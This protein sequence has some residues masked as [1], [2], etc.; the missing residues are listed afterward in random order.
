MAVIFAKDRKI[1][2]FYSDVPPDLLQ[3]YGRKQLTEPLGEIPLKDKDA[4]NYLMKKK[5]AEKYDK[6][7][8]ELKGETTIS[9][10]DAD[11]YAKKAAEEYRSAKWGDFE[12]VGDPEIRDLQEEFT[13]YGFHAATAREFIKL[14]ANFNANDIKLVAERIHKQY[15]LILLREISIVAGFDPVTRA[16]AKAGAISVAIAET[17]DEWKIKSSKPADNIAIDNMG[18]VKVRM[19]MLQACEMLK[20]TK[21]WKELSQ[22][23]KSNY[24]PAFELICGFL[25]KNK[26]VHTISPDEVIWLHKMFDHMPKFLNK[27]KDIKLE[28][29][30]NMRL[31]EKNLPDAKEV[32]SAQTKM[33]LRTIP[34]KLFA[35]LKKRLY[36]SDNFFED[37]F[38]TW[39]NTPKSIRIQYSNQ[40]LQNIYEAIVNQGKDSEMFWIPLIAMHT[41]ARRNELC[42]LTP[43]DIIGYKGVPSFR[44]ADDAGADKTM[45]TG[46]S[47]RIVPIHSN[48]IRAGFLIYVERNKKNLNGRL[49]GGLS[50]NANGWGD[51]FGKKYARM[52]EGKIEE[53]SGKEKVFHSFRHTVKAK[54]E[55]EGVNPAHIDAIL[56]WSSHERNVFERVVPRRKQV[57][58]GYGTGH[59]IE[60]LQSAIEQIKYG[61][62]LRL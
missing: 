57:S 31:I 51:S 9:H 24:E 21:W 20:D 5:Y 42:Q 29:E 50:L 14:P 30:M 43:E 2:T 62:W 45:K 37:N 13:S 4:I 33:K 25:G 54:L 40:D 47:V 44:I 23:T 15:E 16:F 38:P 28:I 49:W 27:D 59:H 3:V 1:A 8:R 26:D 17:P 6:K 46:A 34:M 12:D 39:E 10:E 22:K 55:D 36:I 52:V 60:T 7:R 48:L 11:F 61:D 58:D 35:E 56:G 53:E 19:T 32:I 41:G 18:R